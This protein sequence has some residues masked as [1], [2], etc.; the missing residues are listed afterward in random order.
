MAGNKF[1]TGFK[2]LVVKEIEM[3]YVGLYGDI[4]TFVGTPEQAVRHLM[5]F[6]DNGQ[7]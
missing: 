2:P 5:Q 4:V 6:K 1:D 7:K 3:K